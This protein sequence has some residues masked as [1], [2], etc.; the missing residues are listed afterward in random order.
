MINKYILKLSLK[1]LDGFA[2]IKIAESEII[3]N[4]NTFYLMF[5]LIE[6][7]TK[8]DLTFCVLSDRTKSRFTSYC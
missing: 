7:I 2:S 4:E 1:E 5:G 3:G 6:R 8:N